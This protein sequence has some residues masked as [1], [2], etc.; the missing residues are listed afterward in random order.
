MNVIHFLLFVYVM[1]C[2]LRTEETSEKHHHQKNKN[3]IKK[4]QKNNPCVTVGHFYGR[5]SE[6]K[7]H[8][9][10]FYSI[11]HSTFWTLFLGK[12]DVALELPITDRGHIFEAQFR[13]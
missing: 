5:S 11:L 9:F 7:T 12:K 3:I 10:I 13:V 1:F 8:F 2:D 6:T 4:N